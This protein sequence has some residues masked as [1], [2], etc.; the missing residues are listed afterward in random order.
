MRAALIAIVLV[1]AWPAAVAAKVLGDCKCKDVR[2]LRE[3]WCAARAA[4]AEYQRI[5]SFLASER[6]TT[7]STRMYSLA[8]KDMINQKCVQEAINRATDRGADKATAETIE[9]L[10]TQSLAGKVECRIVVTHGGDNACLKQV[11]EAHEAVHREACLFRNDFLN[12]GYGAALS[13][14]GIS[15]ALGLHYTGDTKYLLST[16]DYAF[17]EETGYAQEMQLIAER[18]KILQQACVA[19]AFVAD[20]DNP[21]TAGQQAWDR[22]Q[23]ASDGSRKYRMYDL[24]SDPCPWRP[25]PPKSECTLR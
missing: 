2:E 3:R 19:E 10:P 15:G 22:A 18:W 6:G 1:A 21:D 9:N 20:L 7:G 14:L 12:R 24:T 25:P 23:P 8:D 5:Q 11:V 4:R 17:E 13:Q 16:S